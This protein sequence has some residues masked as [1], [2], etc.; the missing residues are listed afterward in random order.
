MPYIHDVIKLIR[1]ELPKDIPLIG[2]GGAPFTLASYAIE[3]KGSRN[4][5]FV[6]QMMYGD[7]G[8]WHGL[9][10]KITDTVIDYMN[11]Q[12]DSGVQAVQL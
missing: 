2:F 10:E 7:A 6:K 5:V 4:Y 11:Y 1:A 12:I 8:A 3:G 9:M